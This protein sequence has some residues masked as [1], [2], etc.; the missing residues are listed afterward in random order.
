MDP[1]EGVGGDGPENNFFQNLFP[2]LAQRGSVWDTALGA[3]VGL[4]MS[5]FAQ[6]SVRSAFL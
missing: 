4:G 3:M 5:A 6:L 2:F 1:H